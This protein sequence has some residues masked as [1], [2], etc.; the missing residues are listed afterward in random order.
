MNP[1]GSWIDTV[2]HFWFEELQP[3]AWF[4]AD[5]KLDD[6]IRG[7]FY[8]LYDQLKREAPETFN[9]TAPGCLAAVI[10]LDQFPRNMFRGSPESFATDA[11]ALSIAEHAIRVGLDQALTVQQRQFLYMP[12]QHSEDRAVQARSMQLFAS[13]NDSEVL[14]YAQKHKEIIDRFGR[15]PH[16][17]A[18]L[19]RISSAAEVEFLKTHPGF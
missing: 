1:S 17:N 8:E 16:R 4:T 14:G 6:V 3:L 5:Q 2:L 18:M 13:L 15:F 19:G 7:R 10:V 11:L 9:A 12:F